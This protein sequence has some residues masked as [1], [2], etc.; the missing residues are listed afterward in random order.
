MLYSAR[1]APQGIAIGEGMHRMNEAQW[2]R[3]AALLAKQVIF[4]AA[5]L[6]GTAS[7]G[8]LDRIRQD[9]ALR[10]AYRADAPPFS[11]KDNIGEPA[12]YMVD[13]CRAVA[14]R[15]AQQLNLTS[16]SVVYVQV[17]AVDRFDAI[18]Q[19]KAICSVSRQ[20]LPYPDARWSTSRSRRSSTAPA[21]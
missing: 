5:A 12:G 7:A 10:I 21:S 2:K 11:Y 13:L 8:T 20:A 4:I 3:P 6:A 1:R 18:T 15:L 16:L 9:K 17:T 14:K 19:G